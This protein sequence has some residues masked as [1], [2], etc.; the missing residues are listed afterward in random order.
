MLPQSY[1]KIIPQFILKTPQC[2]RLPKH[3]IIVVYKNKVW[4]NNCYFRCIAI[5]GFIP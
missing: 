4:M 3:I 5:P 1:P 2:K